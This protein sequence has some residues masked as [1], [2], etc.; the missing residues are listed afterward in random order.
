MGTGFTVDTPLKVS[1]LGID[2]VISIGDDILL[3]KMRKMYC[4]EYKLS[5]AEITHEMEDFRAKRITA[6]LNL[7]NDISAMKLDE[8]KIELIKSDAERIRYFDSFPDSS[9]MQQ[10][11]RSLMKKS[12]GLD[13]IANWINGNLSRGSI[14]VNIMTKVDKENYRNG[15]K[16]P[17]E[18]NDAHA[19]LRGYASSNLNS[20]VIFSAGMN[21]RLYSYVE[22]FGDF[23]S[24]ER[25]ELKKKIVIKVSDYRS[26]LIQ[27]KFFA[28]KG[29]WVSEYRIESGLNC[30]G[31]AFATDGYLMGPILAEFRDNRQE[32][33]QTLHD[34]YIIGLSRKN[35]PVSARPLPLRITAQ[36]GVGTA[37]EHQFLIDHYQ[38]D[39]VGWGSPFLLVPEVTNVDHVTLNKLVEAKEDDLY[40]SDISPLGVPFNNL[41]GNT[42]DE[43][44]RS[45]IDK[46]RP[47]SPCVRKFLALNSEVTEK[48]ICTAS[49]QYQKIKIK[50]LDNEGLSSNEY[51]RRLNEIVEKACLCTGLGSSALLVNNLDTRIE[52]DGVSVCPGP[53]LAY[54]SRIVS[55]EQMI[56]H[57]Y[58]RA[59]V[60]E[61][62]DRPNMFIRELNLYIDYLKKEIDK[63]RIS[64]NAKHKQY[65]FRFSENLCTGIQ[66]YHSLFICMENKFKE[67]KSGILKDLDNAR[68]NLYLLRLEVENLLITENTRLLNC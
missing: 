28:K 31:H 67:T 65:L 4:S 50:E 57:I 13:E 39:S 14:D 6:Y 62:I 56:D 26:A 18:Y 61:R 12:P 46:G 45:L 48:S 30:G 21:P 16:L 47:G 3:E 5:Y 9:D 2:S 44:K 34:M 33:I 51:L 1:H 60:I 10:G 15:E 27:G 19:A 49:R 40:L 63:A 20:S 64:L 32:L 43:E 36:G 68:E 8:L 25:G 29:L 59:N 41:K 17:V 38:V 52:G 22:E 23:Y 42:K 58:G 37:E 54:F 11:F 7:L 55:L 24:D 35:R 66:F 53:N